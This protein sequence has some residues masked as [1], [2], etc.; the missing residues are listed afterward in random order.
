M[1]AR[2]DVLRRSADPAFEAFAAREPYYAVLSAPKFLRQHLTSATRDEF[3]ASGDK[4]VA[5]L[6]ETIRLR[7]A[8]HFAP[9]NILEYGCGL[10]RLAFP[11]AR[12]AARRAG[13]VTAVD[14]SRAMLEH[15]RAEAAAR[16]IANIRF[17]PPAE[18]ASDRAADSRPLQFDF[19]VSYLVLQRLRARDGLA[20]I[21]ALVDRTA[22]GGI[23][24]LQFPYAT[25]AAPA[26]RALRRT[27][28]T[29]PFANAAGN[30]LQ[31]KPASQPY[32]R[33]ETYDVRDVLAELE[34]AGLTQLLVVFDDHADLRSVVVLAEVPMGLAERGDRLLAVESRPVS[35]TAVPE[36]AAARTIDVRTL[37]AGSS[38]EA[39]NAAA[40]RYFAGL[41]SP[42]YQLAKP[43]GD[44]SEAPAVVGGVATLLHVLDLAPGM[45]VLDFGCGTGWLSRWLTQ[46]GCR[47]IA[48]D[49]SATALDLARRHVADQPPYGAPPAPRFVLF[50]GHT[51]EV[52]DESVDRI[53]C[54]HAFHHVPNPEAV[55]REFAR[56]LRPGALAAFAEPG[57]H[58]SLMPQSQFEM[59]TY[60]VVENDI[61][62]HWLWDRAQAMGFD[63]VRVAVS[64][65]L[66]F[67]LPLQEFEQL[68]SGGSAG[69]RWLSATRVFL[70]NDR[71]FVLRKAGV[72]TLDSR[73]TAGL[74]CAIHIPEPTISGAPS[75]QLHLDCIVTNTG[76]A[77]WL[78][79]GVRP[80]GV[81]LGAHLYRTNGELLAFEWI[82]EPLTA[83]E[84]PLAPGGEV[85]RRV[86]LPA[87]D[88]GTYFVEL[89]CVA[90]DVTW[91]AQAGSLPQR[92][93]V[94]VG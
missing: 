17:A 37:I 33:T 13:T 75:A 27:R 10:G 82:A 56:V 30:I 63:D 90:A 86:R 74:R 32:V 59:R 83:P 12:Q 61:D 78:A 21:G 64:H 66:P 43:F 81:S 34:R 67:L 69:A 70:R 87:L 22:P 6:F 65:N 42:E 1:R 58:H 38:V 68:L 8:P 76:R 51:I 19:V 47:V 45:T 7:L 14:W 84:V 20:L 91:F 3:F 25:H 39:L 85:K 24:A 73:R 44:P 35:E 62:V 60:G 94:I 5:A 16:A 72:E 15:A 29:V 48:M 36:T 18:I 55:L 80:G 50:D 4:L 9:A 71:T 46:L 49:V 53:V 28:A 52:A 31:G 89:D 23:V 93:R 92:V 77:T 88:R 26:V 40:E 41:G 79:S 11:L 57:P 2:D 54:F